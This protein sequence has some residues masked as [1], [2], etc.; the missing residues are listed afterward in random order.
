MSHGDYMAR[1]N[2]RVCKSADMDEFEFTVCRVA[3]T[4]AFEFM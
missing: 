3:G 2:I 4:D 1:T